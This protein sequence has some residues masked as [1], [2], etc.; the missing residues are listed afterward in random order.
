MTA[1]IISLAAYRAAQGNPRASS[2]SHIKCARLVPDRRKHSRRGELRADRRDEVRYSVGGRC[3]VAF[4]LGNSRVDL[5]NVSRNGFMIKAE[6]LARPGT[7]I[8]ITPIGCQPV[9]ARLIW[10]RDGLAGFEAS[11]VSPELHLL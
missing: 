5:A 9:S 2:G 8:L 7:R 3:T 10:K 11:L 6:L 4:M 1:Q